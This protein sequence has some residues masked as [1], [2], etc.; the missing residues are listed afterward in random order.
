[1][2][3]FRYHLVSI[4]GVFLALLLGIVMGTTVVKQGVIDSLRHQTDNARKDVNS[5]QDQVKQLEAQARIDNMVSAKLQPVL[6][7]GRLAGTSQV[8]VTQQGVDP[9]EVDGVRQV[10]G[11]NQ[12]GG[13]VVG[14]LEITGRMALPDDGSRTALAQILGLGPD[15]SPET[16]TQDAARALATRL[17]AGP[18][19]VGTDTLAALVSAGFLALVGGPASSVGGNGQAVV[20]LS[21]GMQA[22]HPTPQEFLVPL[23]RELVADPG[24]PVPVV[25]AESVDTAYPF[26]PVARDDPAL[27]GRLVTVDDADVMAGRVAVVWGLRDLLLSPGRGANYG[28]KGGATDLLPPPTP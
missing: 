5:L 7:Q 27:N 20:L 23:A 2:I 8:I 11:E 19:E 4:V 12:A 15:S 21:G 16:L 3:S 28:V 18:S 9:A 14:V 22:P 17:M 6:V 13:H 24:N 1:L 25:A 10:L 26:V